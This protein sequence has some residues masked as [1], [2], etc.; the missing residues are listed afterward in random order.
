MGEATK[1]LIINKIIY[2]I[3]RRWTIGCRTVCP[4]L[5][6]RKYLILLNDINNLRLADTETD[7]LCPSHAFAV[8][9]HP[10]QA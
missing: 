4:P 8:H 10:D 7:T 5:T 1:L 6:L 2:L 9:K 3:R